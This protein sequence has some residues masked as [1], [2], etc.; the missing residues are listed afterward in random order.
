MKPILTVDL[1]AIQQN[2]NYLKSICKSEVAVAV[3][4]DSYGLGAAN[5]VPALENVGYS[6]AG[7]SKFF[8]AT[9]EEGIKLRT[10]TKASIYV[11]GGFFENE[12]SDLKH[13]NLTPIINTPGQ[14]EL[15][16]HQ[17]LPCAI[18]I[19]TGMNRLGMNISDFEKIE[20]QIKSSGENIE[21]LMSHL[22]CAGD[23]EGSY[24]QQQLQKFTLA[25]AKYPNIKKSLAASDGIFLGENYHFDIVRSGA[26]IY[27][28][29]ARNNKALKNPVT[30]LAPIIQIRKCENDEYVGYG[31]TKFVKKGSILATIAIGY[32]DGFSRLLSNND[33]LYL[34]DKSVPIIGRISMDLTIIDVTGHNAKLGDMIEILGSNLYPDDIATRA[35]TIGYEILTSLKNGRF[36]CKFI[37]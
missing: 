24:N 26:A 8:V 37:T 5:I 18:H 23:N 13:Y 32:A 12:I 21:F 16:A 28:I 4:A 33:V 22:A 34:N 20:N 19:D 29:G 14:F 17:N 25:T 7:C 11:L 9:I 3:K 35:Q 15:W 10:I 6:K 30:L 1:K 36:S 2:Y 27:G 31:A